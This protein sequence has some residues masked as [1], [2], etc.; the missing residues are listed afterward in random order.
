MGFLD[1]AASA[2]SYVIE[3]GKAHK[4][5]SDSGGTVTAGFIGYGPT[6]IDGGHD[7]RYN[8]GADMTVAQ[9]KGDA[10]PN[11]GKDKAENKG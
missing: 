8:K 10:K 2:L 3:Q 6:K 7:H 4:K 9:K 11:K 5:D 1:M